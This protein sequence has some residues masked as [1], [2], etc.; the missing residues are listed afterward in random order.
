MICKTA[1][2]LSTELCLWAQKLCCSDRITKSTVLVSSALRFVSLGTTAVRA[3]ACYSGAQCSY[4]TP[5]CYMQKAEGRGQGV[6]QCMRT[7]GYDLD[8][9]GPP[10]LR[11]APP[12]RETKQLRNKK[13]ADV[14]E[15]LIGIL[16]EATGVRVTMRWMEHFGIL[17]PSEPVHLPSFLPSF[18]FFVVHFVRSCSPAR[19]MFVRSVLLGIKCCK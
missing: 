9:W 15:S 13:L 3:H 11:N 2:Q 1:T 12:R 5:M 14:M 18:S 4:A 7:A 8:M 16:F 10:A 19:F 17:P 6:R